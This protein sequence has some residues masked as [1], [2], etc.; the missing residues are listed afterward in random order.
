MH[1]A[2]NHSTRQ[3]EPGC[4]APLRRGHGE[5]VTTDGPRCPVNVAGATAHI[6]ALHC[7]AHTGGGEHPCTVLHCTHKGG[8]GFGTPTVQIQFKISKAGHE[9]TQVTAVCRQSEA[10]TR[11]ILRY[12]TIFLASRCIGCGELHVEPDEIPAPAH[13]LPS[14][15]LFA[16]CRVTIRTPNGPDG[17]PLAGSACKPQPIVIGTCIDVVLDVGVHFNPQGRIVGVP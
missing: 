2:C 15:L 11:Q 3:L 12:G 4:Q 1:S 14:A 8:G 5:V 13:L 17:T 7:T 10:G 9:Q 16:C 6:H